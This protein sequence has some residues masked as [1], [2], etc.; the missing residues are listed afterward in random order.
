MRETRDLSS[1][2]EEALTPDELA[3][4]HAMDISGSVYARMRELKMSKGELADRMGVKPS[5][6]TRI[7]RGQA[8]LTIK[9][10]ARLETALGISLSSGFVYQPV[11]SARDMYEAPMPTDGA[12]VWRKETGEPSI[13][14]DSSDNQGLLLV[15]GGLKAA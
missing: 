9:T 3:W 11:S 14:Y 15:K 13:R 8:N 6:I 5:Q 7:I 10:L 2:M 4:D 12:A 1:L